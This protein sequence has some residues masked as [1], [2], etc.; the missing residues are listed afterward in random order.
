MSVCSTVELPGL[1]CGWEYCMWGGLGC[2]FSVWCTS[3]VVGIYT[4]IYVYMYKLQQLKTIQVYMSTPEVCGGEYRWVGG[5]CGCVRACLCVWVS[6]VCVLC[7]R[8]WCVCQY[9]CLCVC[10]W[11][12]CV[13]QV[14]ISHYCHLWYCCSCAQLVFSPLPELCRC[15]VY[16]MCLN[17]WDCPYSSLVHVLSTY[18]FSALPSTPLTC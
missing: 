7:L 13:C 11:I 6:V 10:L 14:V 2:K 15:C 18:Q 16:A 9:I 1:I 5:M 12:W 17:V 3:G 8:E 4:C